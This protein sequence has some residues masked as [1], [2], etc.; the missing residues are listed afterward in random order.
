MPNQ[1]TYPVNGMLET[2][3]KIAKKKLTICQPTSKQYPKPH[4]G[5]PVQRQ[6]ALTLAG[7]GYR[8][9]AVFSNATMDLSTLAVVFSFT[10]RA[11]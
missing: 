2:R 4:H 7:D 6:L 10:P 5:M 9:R 3:M 8:R 1:L 11:I